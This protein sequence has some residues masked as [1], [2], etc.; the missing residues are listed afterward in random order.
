[1]EID[2]NVLNAAR[3]TAAS[4]DAIAIVLTE[5]LLDAKARLG[6]AIQTASPEVVEHA[7]GYYEG[8]ERVRAMLLP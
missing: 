7:N 1:M 4:E 3:R 8:I 5:M 6:S 2:K